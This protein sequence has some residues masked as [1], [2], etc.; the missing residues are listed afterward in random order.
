MRNVFCQSLV[1][2]VAPA[3]VRV[4]DRRP[5]LQ[6]PGAAC[7][8][9]WASG[10]STPA[11]PSRTWS[12]WPPGWPAPAC[13]PGSTAS[14]RSSTPGPSS[15]SATTSA[16]TGCPV[17][18]VGNGGGY[19]YGVMGATHHA[20]ED[21]GALLC[22]PH[23]RAYVPAFD[24][25][26]PRQIERLFAASHPAYLRL[27]LSEEP[28]DVAVPPYAPW[29]R[30]MD[31][32]RLGGPGRRHRWP[33]GSGRPPGSSSERDGP[34]SGCSAN[35]RSTTIPEAFLADLARSRRL[36]VVEEH[37]AHGGVGQM[38][39]GAP[40]RRRLRPRPVRHPVGPGLRLRPVRLAEVPPSRVRPRPGSRSSSS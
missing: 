29:R 32:R 25:D 17:V 23:M 40:A 8:T 4:P 14:R 3:R 37:V 20:L 18:L 30:L 22:L 34:P 6:G 15:R 5:R 19:G 31:G 21:Y 7:A 35:S 12:R 2:A 16:C 10:S 24:G 38:I 1:E 26:L 36:L 39:A 28:A 11:W 13:G 27:G 9:R 33:A